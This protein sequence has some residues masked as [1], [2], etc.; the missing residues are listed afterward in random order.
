MRRNINNSYVK[1]KAGFVLKMRKRLA[2]EQKNDYHEK[3]ALE[4]QMV[5][6]VT[7]AYF[8]GRTIL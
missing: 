4:A 6:N 3:H 2:M 8:S 1:V 5:I 7:S